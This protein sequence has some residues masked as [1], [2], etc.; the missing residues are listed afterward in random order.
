MV[1]RCRRPSGSRRPTCS[2]K[3]SSAPLAS[4]RSSSTAARAI[5]SN[6]GGKVRSPLAADT[7]LI[8]HLDTPRVELLA[9]LDER[10]ESHIGPY[11]IVREL[12]RGG[13]G[14]V[15]LA[16]R[17]DGEYRKRVAIKVVRYDVK[18]EALLRRFRAERQILAN[19]DHPNIT[20]KLVRR[21]NH[22]RATDPYIVHG[23]RRRG[24]DRLLLHEPK[25]STRPASCRALHQRSAR[26]SRS[27]TGNL[28]VHRDLK[29]SK[30]PGRWGKGEP[31]LLDFESPRFSIQRR[32]AR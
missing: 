13:T 15:Y 22:F 3:P 27:L 29:P 23:A 9:P 4:A 2:T 11:E 24:A 12:G 7:N 26:P 8:D 30:R 14:V 10:R 17:T 31:G 18:S 5:T 16:E 21:R 20:L 28:V 1:D 32:R 25:D 6:C 19:L